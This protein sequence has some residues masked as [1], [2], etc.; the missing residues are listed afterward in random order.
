MILTQENYEALKRKLGRVPTDI[1]IL[2]DEES[3][4]NAPEVEAAKMSVVD[5]PPDP[6][7]AGA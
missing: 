4:P 3:E 2:S 1:E 5:I 6:T 7:E